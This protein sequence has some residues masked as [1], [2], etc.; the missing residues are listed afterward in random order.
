MFVITKL[1]PTKSNR[2]AVFFNGHFDFSVDME[3]FVQQDLKEGME[4]T[5]PQY[6]ALRGGTQ[7]RQ[8][9]EKAFRLLSYKSYT[10][11]ML[12]KRLCQDFPPETVEDVIARLEEL[13]LLDDADYALRC[14]KDLVNL[15]KYSLERV[16]QELRRRG[17]DQYTIEDTV[18]LLK[19]ND[20]SGARIRQVLEKKYLQGLGEEKGRR[21]AVNGLVRLGYQYSD[22]K[23]EIAAL[24]EENGVSPGESWEE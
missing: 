19:E 13:H 14:A 3:T 16:K 10:K 6:D 21:R 15:K 24:L 18:V 7:Y 9:K 17:I 4:L 22:I 11:A 8:A 5:G 12:S 2:M 23:R 20:D 1:A